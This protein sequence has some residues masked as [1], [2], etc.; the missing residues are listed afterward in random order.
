MSMY[1]SDNEG[2]PDT[3]W[4]G[5]FASPG[6]VAPASV[7]G[8]YYGSPVPPSDMC[9]PQ[10]DAGPMGFTPA[11]SYYGHS[12]SMLPCTYVPQ[13][14]SHNWQQQH[15]VPAAA[16]K[17]DQD[18]VIIFDWD[19]TLMC[20][21]AINNNQL[22]PHQAQHLEKLLEQVLATSMNLGETYIVT[23]ADNL[24]VLESSRRFAPRVLP[25]LSQIHVVSARLKYEQSCPG[26]VFA[27]KRETFREVLATRKA[28]PSGGLNLVVLGDSPAEM[29]AAQ[30]S[31]LGLPHPV[32]IKTVKFKESPSVDELLAQLHIVAQMLSV[33][34]ADERSCCRNLV[35]WMRP[36]LPTQPMAATTPCTNVGTATPPTFTYNHPYRSVPYAAPVPAI[37]AYVGTPITYAPNS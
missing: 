25:V 8:L 7:A 37:G 12:T 18:L 27:W 9:L 28:V 10:R 4:P 5:D 31:T 36:Q 30:T 6:Q 15:R 23:N 33:I 20:S 26:D 2:L 17:S 35:N 19:D 3:F 34:V 1:Y 13:V 22:Q 14:I 21:S 16:R 29:E 32:V 24:W 11:N